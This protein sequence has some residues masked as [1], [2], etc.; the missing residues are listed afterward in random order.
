[1]LAPLAALPQTV[2]K[3]AMSATGIGALGMLSWLSW[4]ATP[5]AV[6]WRPALALL[7][8]A[9]LLASE[10]VQQNL[11]MGQV[12]L[13]LAVLV[14]NDVLLPDG[15]RAKGCGVGLAAGIKLT[16]P[17][18]RSATSSAATGTPPATLR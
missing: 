17:S 5:V 9:V 13:V 14:L 15:H 3:V 6:R 18:S 16:P 12:N 4:R 11:A 1:V 7:T 8:V 10:P 2:A